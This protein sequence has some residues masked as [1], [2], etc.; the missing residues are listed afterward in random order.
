MCSWTTKKTAYHGDVSLS[1][2]DS[3]SKIKKQNEWFQTWTMISL[4]GSILP[5][6]G[7][8]PVH[9]PRKLWIQPTQIGKGLLVVNILGIS[10]YWCFYYIR[11]YWLYIYIHIHSH[12]GKI[13]DAH[14]FSCHAPL[15]GMEEPIFITCS[16]LRS[17][18]AAQW[19]HRRVSPQQLSRQKSC[20]SYGKIMENLPETMGVSR[21]WPFMM[22]LSKMMNGNLATFYNKSVMHIC[23]SVWMLA[24][25]LCVCMYVRLSV[26]MYVTYVWLM[27]PG[28]MLTNKN[29]W[30]NAHSLLFCISVYWG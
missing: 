16:R 1:A 18:T 7:P 6:S 27:N 17:R 23:M 9:F 21:F 12:F 14:G 22:L 5:N 28:G 3:S 2:F 24:G 29:M 26:C 8:I 20:R 19:G 11:I 25:W 15:W 4:S 30:M 10:S 13:W